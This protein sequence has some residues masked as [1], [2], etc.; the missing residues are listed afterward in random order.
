MIVANKYKKFKPWR[1][2]IIIDIEHLI[3]TGQPFDTT[4]FYEKDYTKG[5]TFTKN[6]HN[7]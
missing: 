5:Q 6:P 7:E 1:D 2:D 4:F 3:D